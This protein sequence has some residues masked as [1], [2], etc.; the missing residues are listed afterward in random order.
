M[1]IAVRSAVLFFVRV[2]Q[3]LVRLW[4]RAMDGRL[5]SFVRPAVRPMSDRESRVMG[6]TM[7]GAPPG[8]TAS[9]QRRVCV[10]RASPSPSR[11]GGH[12]VRVE[13]TSD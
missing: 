9:V 8:R 1:V 13:K 7:T 11:D 6:H 5:V 10:D 4:T 3:V 12:A 2:N